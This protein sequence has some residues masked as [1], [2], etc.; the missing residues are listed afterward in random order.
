MSKRERSAISA[1][2]RRELDAVDA[3]LREE[4]VGAEHTDLAELVHVLRATRPR[5]RAQFIEALDARAARRFEHVFA[6]AHDGRRPRPAPAR[7]WLGGRAEASAWRGALVRPA[8]GVG[9]VVLLLAAVAIPLA[10]SGGAGTHARRTPAGSD[11]VKRAQLKGASEEAPASVELQA[12]PAE[13][14]PGASAPAGGGAA[15]RQIERAATLDVGVTP[16]AI[17]SAAQRVFT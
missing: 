3:A 2:A 15:V 12:A 10:L 4:A 16:D 6:A 13:S 17:Q 1:T 8:L 11:Q 5:A 7:R 14:G 9:L